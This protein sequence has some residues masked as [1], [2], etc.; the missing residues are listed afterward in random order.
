MISR[1][2]PPVGA[3]TPSGLALNI[4]A[5]SAQERVI[6]SLA[7]YSGPF[8]KR[9]A[10]YTA[11][12]FHRVQ[13]VGP[14]RVRFEV[15]GAPGESYRL[16]QSEDLSTRTLLRQ[17]R[18][19]TESLPFEQDVPAT[20]SRHFFGLLE[21]SRRRA[22]K[23]RTSHRGW[24]WKCLRLMAHAG[25]AAS[26]RQAVGAPPRRPRTPAAPGFRQAGRLPL[27]GC[28]RARARGAI[29]K[30]SPPFASSPTD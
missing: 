17:V 13:A 27:P 5:V 23:P 20:A 10:F 12:V 22:G 30:S 7:L 29:K 26:S 3:G 2:A 6:T 18:F 16:E 1:R 4:K 9:A 25:R 28:N 11:A 15:S 24:H 19:E 8:A 14:S 21:S